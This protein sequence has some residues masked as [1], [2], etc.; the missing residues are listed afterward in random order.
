VVSLVLKKGKQRREEK[1][2]GLSSG[3]SDLHVEKVD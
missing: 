2:D 1:A 3:G